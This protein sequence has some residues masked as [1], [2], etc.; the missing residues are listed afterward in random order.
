MASSEQG[1]Q[2]SN[3]G[4]ASSRT[5]DPRTRTRTRKIQ[6]KGQGLKLVEDKDFCRGKHTLV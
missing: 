5:E 1:R 3:A 4:T 6:G 2:L